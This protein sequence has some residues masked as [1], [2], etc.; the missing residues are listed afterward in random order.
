ML[1]LTISTPDTRKVVILEETK[2]P[3]EALS[4][5]NINIGS[6]TLIL[7]G[8]V[9]SADTQRKSFAALGATGEATLALCVKLANA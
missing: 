9:L 6:A 3:R 1:R 7:D 4:E 2:T 5:N 8:Q